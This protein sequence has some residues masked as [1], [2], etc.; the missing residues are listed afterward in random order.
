[1]RSMDTRKNIIRTLKKVELLQCLN[2]QQIQRLADLLTEDTFP[3][4][5]YIIKQDEIGDN[6][7]LIVKGN[8]ICTVNNNNNEI[9]TNEI[10]LNDTKS[11]ETKSNAANDTNPNET[12]VMYLKDNDY[13][14]E[15]A[16]LTSNP[17]AAN[18][19]TKTITKVLYINKTA[20][21][22]VLG[23]LINIIDNHQ[24][25]RE[26][27]AKQELEMKLDMKIPLKFNEIKLLGIIQKELSSYLLL[28][29][30]NNEIIEMNNNNSKKLKT[31]LTIHSFILSQLEKL[32]I[33]KSLTNS[34]DTARMITSTTKKSSF[35]PLLLNI[36]S[37]K[38]AYHLIYQTI[39][40]CDL[41]TIIAAANIKA[42]YSTTTNTTTTA[43]P[44]TNT[45]TNTI[46][47]GIS[48]QQP[49][50][51][52]VVTYIAACI[53]SVL[54]VIH[55]IG[56]IYRAIQPDS[57][58]I[59]NYGK[60]VLIDYRVSKIG[61]TDNNKTFTICGATDYLAP[62]QISQVGHNTSVDL[63][64]LGILLYE[65][66]VG[67]SP[68][69]SI[70]EMTTYSKITSYG[71]KIFPQLIYPDY[72]NNHLKLIINQL[73]VVI[74]ENRLGYGL[75]GYKN[76][77]NHSLFREINWNELE[78]MKSPLLNLANNELT[79]IITE[80]MNNNNEDIT[81]LFQQEYTSNNNWEKKININ[82]NQ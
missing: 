5:H 18:V 54:E 2:L 61:I 30:F 63:W 41:N 19:I 46:M 42:G 75:N 20:F 47:N 72:I 80:G 59:N 44:N 37:D 25:Q 12:I 8:C 7:Y 11:N 1:M 62:E 78:T 77:K 48:Q 56:V 15:K 73:L 64:S 79:D 38:N 74:P 13:F 16:L 10:R 53:L 23:P 67:I 43:S 45:N 65:L 22:E 60:I 76:A 29:S 39:I 50:R 4:N 17:R 66:S 6:F 24:K 21:E 81:L 68:F 51:N 49:L 14:G 31:N 40:V 58:Y 33:I 34:I 70:N 35:I 69:T 52:E 82:G 3:A 71:T 27:L 9:K 36:L 55:E 57:I 28:G 26:L 32:N